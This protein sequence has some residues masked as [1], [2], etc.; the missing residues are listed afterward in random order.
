MTTLDPQLWG[1][2]P[3]WITAIFS[4]ASFM[5]A[6][7][8]YAANRKDKIREQA[9]K[10]TVHVDPDDAV[11]YVRND[12]GMP[13]FGMTLLVARGPEEDPEY[14]NY[15]RKVRVTHTWVIC[16]IARLGP[17][18]VAAVQLPEGSP[19]APEELPDGSKIVALMF[20]DATGRT[21]LRETNGTLR[22]GGMGLKPYLS[23]GGPGSFT[24]AAPVHP[25]TNE[26]LTWAIASPRPVRKA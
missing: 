1:S 20:N 4:S 5:I 8:V 23:M 21:W 6:A 7:S 17:N 13:I 24:G 12:S 26:G 2:I 19:D 22:W 3:T 14:L 11:G 9:S 25:A 15:L 18:A 10:V 16:A